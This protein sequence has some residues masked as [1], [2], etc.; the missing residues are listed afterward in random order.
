VPYGTND[1]EWVK[2]LVYI[3][4]MSMIAGLLKVNVKQLNT[5]GSFQD[6]DTSAY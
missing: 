1:G 3:L 4:Y 5:R 6:K 2:K